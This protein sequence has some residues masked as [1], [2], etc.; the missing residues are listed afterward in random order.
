MKC[1]W[2]AFLLKQKLEG[3]KKLC[4]W[5][6]ATRLLFLGIIVWVLVDAIMKGKLL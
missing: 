6:T 1:T 2:C 5:C 4:T 3:K